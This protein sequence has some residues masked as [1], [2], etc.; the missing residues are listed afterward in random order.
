MNDY[1]LYV[2]DCE[3]T[4]LDFTRH[5]VI[6]VSFLRLSDKVQKTWLLK[7]TN[8]NNIET[9]ALR[10]NGHK[11]EDL[12]HQ[13]KE[14]REKYQDPNKVIVEIENF[15]NEDN[16]PVSNRVLCGQ[17]INFDIQM[18]KQLWFKCGA[19]DSF[20]FGRRYLDTMQIELFM[21]Y[22][23]SSFGEGY[24]LS[25]LIKKYGV[26]NEKA[27]TAAADTRATAEVFE[28]Q[29]QWF[30]NLLKVYA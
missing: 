10:I 13:T 21:D 25:N 11:L 15:I 8:S 1:V 18:L 20:P 30:K 23:K 9:D 24:S 2:A 5:D 28:K 4:G 29:V 26:K 6:E 17:N 16:I 7:P 22:C 19:E 27:H 14:G 3:S 12:L